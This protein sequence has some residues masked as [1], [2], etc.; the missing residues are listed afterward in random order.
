MLVLAACSPEPTVAQK[1]QQ[2]DRDIAQVEAIQHQKPPPQ[3]IAPLPIMFDDIQKHRLFS[4]GCAFAPGNSMG[5]VLLAQDKAGYIKLAGRMIRLASDPGST[6][7][8]PAAWSRYA[9]KELSASLTRVR[10]GG[11]ANG[12]ESLR[13]P[14][15]L[16]VTDAY[17]QVVYDEDGRV[18][19]HG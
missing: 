17:E 19:C 1:A 7:L 11:E 5:A 9:G 16:T 2:D 13:W 15:H 6:R 4:A 12:S 18:E 10:N 14:G 3:P 8:P